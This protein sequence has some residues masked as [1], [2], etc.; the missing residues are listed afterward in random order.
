[1]GY[2]AQYLLSLNKRLGVLCLC[3]REFKK[4]LLIM[5]SCA[6]LFGVFGLKCDKH[7][8]FCYYRTKRHAATGDK[9]ITLRNDWLNL[10]PFVFLR[11]AP[12]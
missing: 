2:T 11:P 8:I 7:A 6:V 3:Y 9:T 10:R 4:T 5:M 1:V 12:V